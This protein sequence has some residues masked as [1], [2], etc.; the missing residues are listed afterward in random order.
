MLLNTYGSWCAQQVDCRQQSI[1]I[2]SELCPCIVWV[3]PTPPNWQHP[4]PFTPDELQSAF[5]L[6]TAQKLLMEV[7]LSQDA[8]M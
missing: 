6:T 3:P 8:L 7:F 2:L 4:H 5:L 1:W